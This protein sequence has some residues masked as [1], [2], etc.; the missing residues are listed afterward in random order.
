MDRTGEEAS[1]TGGAGEKKWFF[2]LR[3][4][5]QLVVNGTLHRTSRETN[6]KNE[7]TF[8]YYVNANCPDVVMVN[9]HF[10]RQI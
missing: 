10:T 9:K 1:S 4:N 8:S 3:T 2:R 6:H 5:V 7:V